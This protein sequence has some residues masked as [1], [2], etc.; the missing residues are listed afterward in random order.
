MPRTLVKSFDI[1]T[2]LIAGN[3]DTFFMVVFFN[4]VV[5]QSYG[6]EVNMLKYMML[7]SVTKSGPK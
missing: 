6:L 5:V 4:T 1:G 2:Y 7:K 3:F